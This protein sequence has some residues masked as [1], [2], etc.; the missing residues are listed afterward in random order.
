MDNTNLTK[1]ALAGGDPEPVL[2][3]HVRRILVLRP[4]FRDENRTIATA[5][6]DRWYLS[7]VFPIG[8]LVFSVP[9][10]HATAL[11]H[12]TGPRSIKILRFPRGG[13]EPVELRDR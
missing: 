7:I 1:G 9:C 8:L 6:M 4:T 2:L 11:D 13:V 12:P 3:S 10:G 5:T